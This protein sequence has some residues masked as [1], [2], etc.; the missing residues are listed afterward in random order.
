MR[1][2]RRLPKTYTDDL[3]FCGY[4]LP[5]QASSSPDLQKPNCQLSLVKEPMANFSSVPLNATSC[6]GSNLNARFHFAPG[7]SS[8]AAT[9][10]TLAPG[11]TSTGLPEPASAT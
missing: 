6:A 8:S 3:G 4:L 5:R 10:L 7:N 1:I 11:C 9:T 2:C